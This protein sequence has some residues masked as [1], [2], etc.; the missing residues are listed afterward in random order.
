MLE[1]NSL[2]HGLVV[3]VFKFIQASYNRELTKY[4]NYSKDS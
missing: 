2:G 3:E 4:F 1:F